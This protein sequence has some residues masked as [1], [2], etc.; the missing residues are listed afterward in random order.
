MKEKP[1]VQGRRDFIKIGTLAG[2]G[3]L[4]GVHLP[5]CS[6]HVEASHVSSENGVNMLAPNAWIRIRSDDTVTVMVNHSEL[7]Q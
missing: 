3:L 5:N 2:T 4:V 6:R 7:G 1:L